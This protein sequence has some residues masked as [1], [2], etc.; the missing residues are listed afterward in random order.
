[1]LVIPD[2]DTQHAVSWHRRNV[3]FGGGAALV[4][5][6]VLT[7]TRTCALKVGRI[8]SR[9]AEVQQAMAERGLALPVYAYATQIHLPED[10]AREV[11]GRHG[12]RAQDWGRGAI[13]RGA[14]CT[15]QHAQDV[16]AMP[17]V[18][19]VSHDGYPARAFRN[20][21]VEL[22]AFMDQVVHVCAESFDLSW[23]R[24]LRNVARYRQRWVALD[25]GVAAAGA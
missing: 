15:C 17:V 21:Q 7:P 6:I 5:H 12:W 18:Q 25:F 23:D 24:D 14:H 20:Q 22:Q 1:M 2:G 16:L 9:E 11:C 19:P 10:V 3:L 4:Y 13:V 8:A